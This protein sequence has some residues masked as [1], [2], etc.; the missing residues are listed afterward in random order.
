ME[1]V[2]ADIDALKKEI[3]RLNTM[4]ENYR[5]K[6]DSDS[7][8]RENELFQEK[9]KCLQKEKRLRK[10]NMKLKRQLGRTI[11]EMAKDKSYYV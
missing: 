7:D 6:L 3:V 10:D 8:K 4:V 11:T 9:C 5:K 1:E 2:N